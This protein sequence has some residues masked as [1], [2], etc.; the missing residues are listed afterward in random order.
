MGTTRWGQ[1]L[2]LKNVNK[3]DL[4]PKR[5]NEERGKKSQIFEEN[6]TL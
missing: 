6:A 3:Q 5:Y 1:T 4:T 2:N